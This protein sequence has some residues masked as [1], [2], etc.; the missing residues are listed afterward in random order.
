MNN[1]VKLTLFRFRLVHYTLQQSLQSL[2]QGRSVPSHNFT[3]SFSAI[4]ICH[5]LKH[6]LTD[7]GN[8]E[9]F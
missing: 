5:I 3:F 7:S 9:I 8:Y 6:S 1:A 4:F 2:G